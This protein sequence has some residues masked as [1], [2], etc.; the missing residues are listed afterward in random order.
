[1]RN[2]IMFPCASCEMQLRAPLHLAGRACSC[3]ACGERVVVPFRPPAEEPPVLVMD[4]GY[5]RAQ[6]RIR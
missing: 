1:M 4:D 6:G 5:G 2:R 3:P